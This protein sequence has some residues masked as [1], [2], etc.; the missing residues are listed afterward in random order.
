MRYR[1]PKEAAG[2]LGA[3]GCFDMRLRRV[4][5][6]SHDGLAAESLHLQRSAYAPATDAR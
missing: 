2:L 6:T 4:G 1:A 3:R 5:A